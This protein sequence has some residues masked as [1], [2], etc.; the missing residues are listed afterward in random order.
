MTNAV[1]ESLRANPEV[2]QIVSDAI[3]DKDR[4]GDPESVLQQVLSEPL[5]SR[6]VIPA[7]GATA[8]PQNVRFF[9]A[10]TG[11]RD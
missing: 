6:V 2:Q 9:S 10:P 8:T 11:E 5:W 1:R 7:D 4:L 3:Y